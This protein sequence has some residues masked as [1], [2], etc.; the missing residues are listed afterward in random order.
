M[1][2]LRVAWAAALSGLVPVAFAGWS[3][4]QPSP[5]TGAE[6]SFGRWVFEVVGVAGSG[7]V[8]AV[9]G[10]VLVTLRP[11]N[12]LGWLVLGLGLGAAWACGLQ[13]Y[14][15]QG[16]AAGW[17]AADAADAAGYFLF[18]VSQYLMITFLLL[19]YPDGRLPGPRWRWVAAAVVIV[20]PVQGH[21][22]MIAATAGQVVVDGAASLLWIGTSLTA[23]AGAVVRL[24]RARPP[25]RQQQAWLV[26][27]VVP[28][29]VWNMFFASIPGEGE[30]ESHLATFLWAL[31]QLFTPVAVAVGVLRYRLLG[32]ESVLRRGLVYGTLTVLVF[33]VYVGVS[34]VA[35]RLLAGD[36]VPALVAA[37]LVALGLDPLRHRLQR[38]ADRIVHGERHDPLRA[39]TRLSQRV[40]T[41]EDAALL[42]QALAAVA[43]AVRA[44]GAAVV[45]ADG[46]LIAGRP[47]DE[48]GAVV[49]LEF[50][51]RRVGELHVAAPSAEEDYGTAERRLLVALAAQLAVVVRAV[52]LGVALEASRDRVVEA[53]RAERD[54]LRRDLHDG[55]GPSLTGMGLGL[56]AVADLVEGPSAV[57]L[58]ERIREE[59]TTA[60]AEI[61]RIIDDLRPS[62][63]DTAGLA[64]AVGRHAEAV[65]AV[66]PVVVDTAG[67]PAT[68]PP[69]V[70]TAAYR[71]ATEALTNV[72]RHS[73]ARRAQVEL[74]AV[75]GTLRVT[76]TDDGGGIGEPTDGVG[77]GSMRRRAETLGGRLEIDSSGTGTAV[78]AFLPLEP[79]TTGSMPGS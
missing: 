24:V 9:V 35:G 5:D 3:L 33:A 78:T 79:V 53:A 29:A 17:P 73:G 62:V 71:I 60:V 28:C 34:A 72:A 11:R 50:A 41:S 19:F 45:D 74:T 49:P 51:G 31:P 8:W 12:V 48:P 32:I 76:V 57:T 58:V 77:L 15:Y 44:P 70:E 21:Y 54:R 38:V 10:A 42:P 37:A 1:Y 69:A 16:V 22:V 20:S 47:C 40:A 26:L 4:A 18:A 39:L 66:L 65:S 75:D 68:L 46:R 27:V 43:E 59:V 61:R 52:E 67:L 64:A 23:W 25:Q 14:A 7:L 30:A 36:T 56:Q 63:L 55:L 2:R 6:L 13:S